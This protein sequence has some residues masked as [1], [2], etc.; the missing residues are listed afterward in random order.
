VTSKPKLT[1]LPEGAI[2]VAEVPKERIVV[3]DH[4]ENLRSS[5]LS[6]ETIKRAGLYTEFEP[7]ALASMLRWKSWPRSVMGS[8]LVFPYRKPGA[9]E[10]SYCRVRPTKPRTYTSKG[11]KKTRK[12]EQPD[13]TPTAP[14]FPPRSVASGAL[15]DA[16]TTLYLT[17]GEKKTLILDQLGYTC[18]GF[19]G[20]F[21]YHDVDKYDKRT[22]EGLELHPWLTEHVTFAGREC[23]IVYD[24]D[25]RTNTMNQLAAGRLAGLLLSAGAR[26]VTMA[27]P[28]E[29]D[30]KWGIDDYF[31][32]HGEEATRR[33]LQEGREP[34][35][36]LKPESPLAKVAS[37]KALREAPIPDGLRMPPGYDIDARTLEL[38]EE[39]P[40]EGRADKRIASSPLFISR[41]L[42]DHYSSEERVE[43]TFMRGQR[44]VV[45]CVDRKAIAD[46]NTMVNDLIPLGAPVTSNNASKLV[47]W[48][49]A[50][51]R[52]NQGR[53]ERV[54]CVG[55]AGWHELDKRWLFVLDGPVSDDELA[56]DTRGDRRNMFAALKP[57]GDFEQHLEVLRQTWNAD[58]TAAVMIAGALAAPLLKRLSAP[59]FA[60]HLPGDSSRGK[61]SMLK[62]AASVYGNPLDDQW[63]GNWNTT[64]VAAELRAAVLTDLPL[65]FDEVGAG[66]AR[67]TERLVYMLIN[68]GGKSRGGRDLQLRE[69]T[70]WRTVLLSTGEHELADETTNTGA[71]IRVLQ[72]RVGGFGDL[73]ADQV[74]HLRD[75]AAVHHGH[76]GR[77]WVQQLLATE[78]WSRALEAFKDFTRILRKKA[79]DPLQQRTAIYFAVL[80]TAES[81][82][83]DLFDLGEMG[84]VTM[85]RAFRDT[86]GV[87]NEVRP[88]AD[89]VLDDVLDWMASEPLAFPPLGRSSAGDE[90][91]KGK[92]PIV[93]GYLR[94]DGTALFIPKELQEF[95]GKRGVSYREVLRGWA[96]RKWIDSERGHSTKLVRINGNRQ[97][98]IV[99]RPQHQEDDVFT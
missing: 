75:T 9:G 99:L 10:P 65:C 37:I 30:K 52:V 91:S 5:G 88:V 89:R 66:D 1:E 24:A 94:D 67:Q 87:R 80:C 27:L 36:P 64:A 2:R 12:Y 56:L 95:C 50:L 71:Q 21:N 84:G 57:K 38:W 17:E 48:F 62:I 86:K 81:M 23:V 41:T 40:D 25:T 55:R 4:A 28:P 76:V 47:D 58:L 59:N 6:D 45:V 3:K 68:G 83:H 69:T 14:Y 96:D 78:D 53:L 16:S 18:V 98:V 74:D 85:Q 26:S 34:I 44:W 22:K 15:S 72:F 32:A 35:E 19:P 79:V 93:H 42:V 61:T 63:V 82:A 7:R 77:K 49:E 60:I 13:N 33:L 70:S 97:R 11:K 54:T 39:A 8:A 73:G 51:E 31:V 46:R 29:P 92:A 43:V 20:V 90:E